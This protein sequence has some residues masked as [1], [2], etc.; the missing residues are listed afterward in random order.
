MDPCAARGTLACCAP[1]SRGAKAMLP[2]SMRMTGSQEAGCHSDYGPGLAASAAVQLGH[3][4]PTFIAGVLHAASQLVPGTRHTRSDDTR[5]PTREQSEQANPRWLVP[6]QAATPVP[7][8]SLSDQKQYGMKCSRCDVWAARSSCCA[9]N[10]KQQNE[11]A[12]TCKFQCPES[13]HSLVRAQPRRTVYHFQKSQ[14]FWHCS[15][16]VRPMLGIQAR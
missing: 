1:Q 14:I 15:K 3:C 10:S 8:K 5:A 9:A 12:C 13:R 16:K 4:I 11:I 6:P 2:H 7:N